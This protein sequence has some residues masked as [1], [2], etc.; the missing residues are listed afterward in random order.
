MN[1]DPIEDAPAPLEPLPPKH[2]VRFRDISP[3]APTPEPTSSELTGPDGGPR[4]PTAPE[5]PL[6]G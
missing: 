5:G 1:E 4:C 6:P 3:A 2:F